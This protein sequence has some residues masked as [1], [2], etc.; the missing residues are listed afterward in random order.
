MATEISRQIDEK[1]SVQERPTEMQVLCLGLSRTG[2]MCTFS[3]FSIF[4]AL[5]AARVAIYTALNK[6]GYN[7]YH[8]AEVPK[9]KGNKHFWY[10]YEAMVIKFYSKGKPYGPA[11][12]DK[13]LENYSVRELVLFLLVIDQTTHFVWAGCDWYPL[14]PIFGWAGRCLPKSE[15]DI[16]KSRCR[17]MASVNGEVVH[18]SGLETDEA[19]R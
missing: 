2:T 7:C 17:Q 8:M 3:C 15:G 10:W 4:I 1:P 6:L 14:H 18:C 19:P 5:T 13:V 12:L 9:N 16:D 11:E